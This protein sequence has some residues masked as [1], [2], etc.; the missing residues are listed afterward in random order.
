[1][2]AI[3]ASE[4]ACHYLFRKET[5]EICDPSRF[6]EEFVNQSL[7]TLMRV[8]I[9]FLSR[10]DNDGFPFIDP[11]AFN[12][13]CHLY[14]FFATRIKKDYKGKTDGE[15]LA[16]TQDN[17][18]LHLSFLLSY[19][20]V[21]NRPLLGQAIEVAAKKG[22][23][24]LPTDQRLF[25]E[26]VKD[27]GGH[28]TRA[29]RQSLNELFERSIK[30]TLAASQE[31]S[32]LH[33]ELHKLSLEDLKQALEAQPIATDVMSPTVVKSPAGA[34]AASPE[35]AVVVKTTSPATGAKSAAR[36]S[37]PLYTM[38]KLAGVAYL[39]HETFAF[40]IKA[41]V[42][43]SAGTGVLLY[44]NTPARG[45]EPV[46]VFEAMASEEFSIDS[47][48]KFAERCPTYFE[49]RPSK[50]DRHKETEVCHF[51]NPT[52]IDVKPYHERFSKAA[53]AFPESLVALAADFMKELQ[54][55]FEKFFHDRE[56]YPLLSD[57]FQR[58]I[59]N[60]D[61]LGLSMKKPLAFTITRIYPDNATHALSPEFRMNSSPES[62][63]STRGFI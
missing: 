60:I 44:Q 17:R 62:F 10:R 22:E 36:A 56:K 2:A 48:R 18:F 6:S 15:K 20:F 32:L 55:P 50:K 1:M 5:S 4:S 52:T 45:D 39:I 46:V 42:V 51:C 63:L 53:E 3:S 61:K 26:F 9:A 58:G 8:N 11:V 12:N 38:P 35:T 47:F 41:K 7:N 30:D 31:R 40:V 25:Y 16:Q 33:K 24:V 13:Q 21:I 49:R 43:T 29:A 14:S 19:I 59:E 37:I 27:I 54:V 57:L 23:I 34:P 28:L